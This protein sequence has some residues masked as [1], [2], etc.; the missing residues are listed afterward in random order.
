MDYTAKNAENVDF[1][2][3]Y[4]Y[5]GHLWFQEAPPRPEPQP[6]VEPYI[7]E[8]N[9]IMQNEAFDFALKAAPNVLYGRYKQ[10]GQLGVLAWCSEFGEMI[11]SLKELGFNGNMFVTTRVQAL[12]TCEDILKLRL[13]IKMQI[14]LMYLSSQVARLRRFLDGERVWDDYPAPEFPLDYRSYNS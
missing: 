12:R 7:P 9:V 11:D 13:D 10:Y 3:E 14:I 4:D 6:V 2:G 8:T 1:G 5:S